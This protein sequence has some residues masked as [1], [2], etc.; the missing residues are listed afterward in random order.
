MTAIAANQLSTVPE[1]NAGT[2]V[3]QAVTNLCADLRR[4]GCCDLANTVWREF[5]GS[6]LAVTASWLEVLAIG[7]NA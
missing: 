6:E 7:G 5:I 3:Y 2:V 4:R 1:A